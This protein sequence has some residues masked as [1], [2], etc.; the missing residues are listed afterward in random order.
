MTY[1]II[2]PHEGFQE[3]ALST[4]ADIAI[5][6]G[7]AGPGKTWVSL[8]ELL[9]HKDNSKFTAL[10]LRRTFA[11]I[12]NAGGLWDESVLMFTP[13]KARSRYLKDWTFKSGA[14]VSFGHLQY[15]K[16]LQNYQGAQI[17]C[18]VFDELTHFTEKMFTYMLS[19]N[20]SVS[21]V[22]P[23]IRA[24][25][26]PDPNSWV[27]RF[28]EWWIDQDTGF[29]IPE[30]EGKLRYMYKH[31][32][33]WLWG[34]SP[35]ELIEKYD[36]I[37]EQINKINKAAKA[38]VIK[39]S[40]LIKSVTFIPGRLHENPTILTKNPQ[41]YANLQ[42][43]DDDDRAR[44]LDGNWKQGQDPQAIA[45]I[46][47][48]S[49]IFDNYADTRKNKKRFL[50]CDAARYGDDFC[51]IFVFEGNTV[52]WTEVISKSSPLDINKAIEDLRLK[53]HIPKNHCI[54]DADGVG[55]KSVKMSN[56][57]GASYVPF[58]NGARPWVDRDPAT[59][60]RMGD[61]IEYH[62]LKDQ[63]VYRFLELRVN[64]YE[65]RLEINSENCRIDGD[66]T[67]KIKVAGNVRDVK[68]LIKDD[69]RS[70]RR[71]TSPDEANDK[72]KKKI[73]EKALQKE[74]LG[75]SPDFG[76][77]L[78][79]SELIYLKPRTLGVSS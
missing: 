12:A 34:D 26:N 58:H 71:D 41:Y 10:M 67:T 3:K 1:E 47:A 51:V 57:N 65:L 29:P 48:V 66:M 44:L 4:P 25:C 27:A 9:R 2:E 43:L 60:R 64:N 73:E 21:G 75:R 40:D 78:M 62:T 24:T 63:C 19:R 45:D 69:L 16:D 32:D 13:W 5:I 39:A 72:R 54:V 31:K 56:I 18:I 55:N 22:K 52:K 36:V 70:Y 61:R 35:D 42:S 68:D 59:N 77:A 7:G 11:Q 30:R 8:F 76:D 53:F 46:S 6:G 28:I 79:M 49:Q 33:L 74:R 50:V 37:T 38:E 14:K 20:R 23:Y 15:E 17:A